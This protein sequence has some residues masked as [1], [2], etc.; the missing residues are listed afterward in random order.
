MIQEK[1]PAERGSPE[2][3]V[4]ETVTH[5]FRIGPDAVHYAGDLVPA[6]FI[7]RAFGDVGTELSLRSDGDE[8][9]LRA[10]ESLEFLAPVYAGDF[11]EVTGRTL[12]VGRTS[13]RR[14]YVARVYARTHG[15]GPHASSGTV[16]AEPVVV[17]RGIAVTV[18][19]R[20]RQRGG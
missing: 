13:R 2:P 6:S 20:E 15:V 11:L 1:R 10:Y 3:A 7:L 4:G 5:R 12:S 8:G 16:L 19:P 17:A 18:V 14:E 9:L